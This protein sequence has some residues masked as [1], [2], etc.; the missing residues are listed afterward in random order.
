M[1]HTPER[2]VGDLG[3]VSEIAPA[4][5]A[6]PWQEGAWASDAMS[7]DALAARGDAASFAYLYRRHLR[8][9]YGY[10]YA[11]LGNTHEAED[12]TS[13]AFER[14]WAGLKKY[15]P[16]V[17]GSFRGWLLTVAHH[18]LVDRYRRK[19]AQSVPIGDVAGDLHD[20]ARGPEEQAV[21]SEQVRQVLKAIGDLSREQQEVVGLRFLGELAYK[22]I[23]N[24][25]GKREAAVKMIAYRAL[26]E[27]RRRCGDEYAP[28]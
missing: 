18:A 16:N 13:L 15:K 9:V 17:T 11:R 23:A 27:I 22:E 8:P 7:D 14:A 5:M 19:E 2:G 6:V 24:I 10:L 20:P 25:V 21:V 28:E 26:E 12:L 3:M 4:G 1:T